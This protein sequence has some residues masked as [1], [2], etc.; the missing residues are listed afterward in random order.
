M[1]LIVAVLFSRSLQ[2]VWDL[3]VADESGYLFWGQKGALA[4]SWGPLYGLWYSFL[5]PLVSDNVSLFYFNF[6]VLIILPTVLAFI[7]L[8]SVKETTS[9]AMFG[10]YYCLFTL[11]AIPYW[12]KVG[13]FG[14]CIALTFLIFSRAAS[15]RHWQMFILTMGA[16][17]CSYIH[18]E[19][20]L[21]FVL[22]ILSNI[23]L[24]AV[25]ILNSSTSFRNSLNEKTSFQMIVLAT[26]LV[27]FAVCVCT[28]H[29]NPVFDNANHSTS[30]LKQLLSVWWVKTQNLPHNPWT[31]FDNILSPYFGDLSSIW[32]MLYYNPSFIFTFLYS[33]IARIPPFIFSTLSTF[34]LLPADSGVPGMRLWSARFGF[35]TPCLFIFYR[36]RVV[37]INFRRLFRSELPL[38]I[39]VA[40]LS[41]TGLVCALIYGPQLH[42]TI[43]PLAFF[44]LSFCILT[45][46]E[47]HETTFTRRS[48][49]LQVVCFV[50]L[51]FIP[52]RGSLWFQNLNS[53]DH[54]NLKAVQ[55]LNQILKADNYTVFEAE[56]IY[57]AYVPKISK[58]VP[59]FNRKDNFSSVIEEEK[60]DV[61]IKSDNLLKERWLVEDPGWKSFELNPLRYGFTELSVPSTNRVVYL[62]KDVLK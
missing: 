49:F 18:S 39:A 8:K 60:V 45:K 28:S 37:V 31:D 27:I 51:I 42:Y 19:F 5:T 41:V 36:R 47:C 22:L 7:A 46:S 34:Y 20:F 38:V 54:P 10:A 13:H 35:L 53:V 4:L 3:Q 33:N 50:G 21:T 40:C 61:I 9:L 58:T 55:F 23:I 52:P 17:I 29:L 43:T 2:N 15:S 26:F 48:L 56:N 1:V 25:T 12:T 6:R 11:F 62:R 30:A 57:R 32:K 24:T 16:F 59:P 14:L 44:V